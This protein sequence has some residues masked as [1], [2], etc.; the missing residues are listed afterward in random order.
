MGL[1]V[2]EVDVAHAGESWEEARLKIE[3]A[4]DQALHWGHKG[5]K[6]VHGRG[7]STGRAVIAPRAISY[8]R[9]LAEQHDGR[10]AR[11]RHNPGA[12]I[13]WLNN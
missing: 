8:L 13:I 6:I 10:F 9:H 2:L 5:L 12:S 1:G 3:R 11:D 7:A 4:L